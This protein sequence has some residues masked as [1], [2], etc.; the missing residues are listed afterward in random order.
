MKRI[1]IS[2]QLQ[3]D[4]PF[5]RRLEAAGYL[6]EGR[7]LIEFEAVPFEEVPKTDWIFFYS[8]R[9]VRYFFEG[10]DEIPESKWAVIGPGT[11][12]TLREQGH[13]ADFTGTGDPEQTAQNFLDVA[14]GRRVLF[15]R[16]RHSRRSVQQRLAGLIQA[17]DLIVYDNRPSAHVPEKTYD[18][19]VFTSPM[20]VEAYCRQRNIRPNQRVIAIG[21]TT[22][23]ALEQRGVNEIAVAATPSEESLAEV[24]MEE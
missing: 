17:I 13:R 10:I 12:T 1:F 9:S 11:K 21:R 18:V 24:V 2:R 20:S 8:R 5:R 23:K 16:A 7:S 4:S 3:T 22:A 19:L 15:P 6:V 14:R